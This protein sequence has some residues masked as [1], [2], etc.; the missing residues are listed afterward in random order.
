MS[1]LISRSTQKK[2]KTTFSF[3]LALLMVF[4]TIGPGIFA[5]N[6]ANAV[7]VDSPYGSDPISKVTVCHYNNG[8]GGQ[9]NVNTVG[10]SSSG[11]PQGGHSH[12]DNDIIPPYFW[13]D[14]F[15]SGYNWTAENELIWNN[16]G[17]NGPVDG[18]GDSECV[19]ASETF[20][21][22]TTTK[23]I[24]INGAPVNQNSVI[25]TPTT[26]TDQ[27]W[28]AN[29]DDASWI[30]SEDPEAIFLEDN[31]NVFE[32]T[33]TITGAPLSASIT[34]ASDNTYD[35][36]V[37]GNSVP[38]AQNLNEDMANFGTEHTYPIDASL[39]N[40]GNN[41][42]VIKVKNIGGEEFTQLTNPAGLKYSFTWNSDC[43]GG[44]QCV[45]GSGMISSEEETL[46]T[47]INDVPTPPSTFAVLVQ[48][49]AAIQALGTGVW[50]ATVSDLAAK[51]IWSENHVSGWEDDKFVTFERHFNIT[52]NPTAGNLEIAADNSYEVWV[53]GVAITLPDEAN[54]EEGD[55]HYES[56]T[57]SVL[58]ALHTGDNVLTIKVKNWALPGPLELN[59]GGL[60]YTLNWDS[61]CGNDDP[62][63]PTH[64][65]T[66]HKFIDGVAADDTDASFT[67]NWQTGLNGLT[68]M[69]LNATTS[70]SG[71]TSEIVQGENVSWSET[72][73]GDTVS[74]AECTPGKFYLDGYTWN[75]DLATAIAN[76]PDAL[77]ETNTI[78]SLDT[79][80][81]VV[82]WNNTCPT[83]PPQPVGTIEITKYECPA[84]TIVTR[85]LNGVG[86]TVPGD[87]VL[88][89][90]ATFGYV[91]GLQTDANAP[92]PELSAALTAGGTTT[93][94]GLLTISNLPAE[95]RYLIVE[96]GDDGLKLPDGDILGLYCEDDGD[97][98]NTNDNQELTFVEANQTTHCVAYNKAAVNDVISSDTP[99]DTPDGSSGGNGNGNGNGNGGGGGGGSRSGQQRGGSV[100]GSSNSSGSNGQVLGASTD[101]PDLPD[102][103]N[104]AQS[105]TLMTS[106]TLLGAL[107][108]INT[109]AIRRMRKN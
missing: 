101:L 80:K 97:V 61:N 26:I 47:T 4:Q 77:P 95:G 31:E 107:F 51:W 103:G 102:T 99:S 106:L 86:G 96:T 92:Y 81:H 27:Y 25:V 64:T 56:D 79:D 5:L 29:I 18:G 24:S 13:A 50:G 39:L 48:P 22:D 15:Y 40:S 17:C 37:N 36:S 23:L 100:A 42:L 63:N 87:C 60:L 30:W 11:A 38:G 41:T 16:G 19:P 33:F 49:I 34:L 67:V 108:A 90:G 32:K 98:T 52:G 21:S 3:A 82:V 89:S 1:Y 70:F 58:S 72:I 68:P 35:V 66:F 8:Q 71:V 94:G 54:N 93:A 104:G 45:P 76:N 10:I 55:N 74:R 12:H 43:G 44:P 20:V 88:E 75:V 84:D 7:S 105:Q 62:Q 2:M 91:H 28:T 57:V 83:T 9:Y 46:V 78:P 6:I 65:V 59:P 73:T 109:V 69:V 85:G 14:G 53:N